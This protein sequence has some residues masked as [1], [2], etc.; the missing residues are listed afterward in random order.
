M[1]ACVRLR[2]LFNVVYIETLVDMHV[3][4]RV[5]FLSRVCVTLLSPTARPTVGSGEFTATTLALYDKLSTY[6]DDSP[7]H[8]PVYLSPGRHPRTCGLLLYVLGSSGVYRNPNNTHTLKHTVTGN[9][10]T[11]Q[12]QEKYVCGWYN[13]Q[14]I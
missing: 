3:F 11:A 6:E 9:G 1:R 8:G 7:S 13:P 4:H 14:N 10:T 2:N 5:Q 12:Q